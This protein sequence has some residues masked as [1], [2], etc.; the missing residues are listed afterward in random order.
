[1]AKMRLGV[2]TRGSC[3]RV[4]ARERCDGGCSQG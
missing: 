2:V 3:D 1:M 4:V